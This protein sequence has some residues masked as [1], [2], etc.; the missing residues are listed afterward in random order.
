MRD[1]NPHCCQGADKHIEAILVLKAS[2]L[3]ELTTSWGS[4][5]QTGI[6]D[7]TKV[8]LYA[9]VLIRGT[10]NFVAAPLVAERPGR[11]V[12]KDKGTATCPLTMR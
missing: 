8:A 7:G 5:F 2:M 6:I 12:N 11:A 4:L 3:G 10:M 9:H 1:K